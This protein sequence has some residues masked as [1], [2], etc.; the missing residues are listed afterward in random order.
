MLMDLKL[1]AKQHSKTS[2]EA[3]TILEL[4]VELLRRDKALAEAA[5]ILILTKSI[6]LGG[7]GR[8]HSQEDRQMI[9]QLIEDAAKSGARFETAVNAIG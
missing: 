2:V 5:T 9:R 7:R 3:R 4:E 6:D 8:A 1:P